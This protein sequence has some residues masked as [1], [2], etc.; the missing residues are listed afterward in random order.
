MR[1]VRRFEDDG[2]DVPVN[3]LASDESR[4]TFL[5]YWCKECELVFVDEMGCVN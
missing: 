3:C 1:N 4:S 2:E 5:G